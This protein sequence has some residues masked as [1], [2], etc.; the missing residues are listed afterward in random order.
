MMRNGNSSIAPT[1][2]NTRPMVSPTILN[3]SR[4]SQINGNRNN[5]INAR[6]QHITN[7]IHQRIIARS[8]RIS[9]LFETS[10]CKLP[11]SLQNL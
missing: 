8:V 2:L 9:I 4:M 10:A 5:I 3:G 1:S 6:G 11:A 7:K